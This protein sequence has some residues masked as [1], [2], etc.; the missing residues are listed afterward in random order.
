MSRRVWLTNSAAKARRLSDAWLER[1]PRRPSP[2]SAPASN[3]DRKGVP[4]GV[5]DFAELRLDAQQLVVL[6]HAVGA[7]QRAGLDLGGR[8]RDGDVGDR[9]SLRS[10]PSDATRRRRSCALSAI[11]MAARVSVSVPIWFGLMRMALAMCLSMP[12]L[13]ILVFVT[14]RSSPTS[15]S[16]SPSSLVSMRPA[17]PIALGHAVLDGDDRVLAGQVGEIIGELAQT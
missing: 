14:N 9:A 7:R 12:S 13:R 17:V 10:R 16:F 11:S 8:G 4:A 5:T 6:G 1:H 3:F 15:C 2:W